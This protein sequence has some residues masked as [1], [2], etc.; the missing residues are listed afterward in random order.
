MKSKTEEEVKTYFKIGEILANIGDHKDSERFYAKI[1]R[2]QGQHNY[3]RDEDL[4]PVWGKELFYMIDDPLSS[5][6]YKESRDY[7]EL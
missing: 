1:I 4:F 3:V 7:S 5:Q 6:Q 2:K